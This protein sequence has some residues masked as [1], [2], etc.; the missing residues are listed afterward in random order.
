MSERKALLPP[1]VGGSSLLTVFAVLC[2][3]VFTVLAL[4]TVQANRRLGDLS[5]NAVTNYYAADCRAEAVLARL[6]AGDVPEGV[7]READ[8]T[9]SYACPV[10]NSQTLA[11]RVAVDGAEYRILRWQVI[12]IADWQADDRFPVWNG[13]NEQGGTA[14]G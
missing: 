3:T 11:V 6:R 2:L 12:S 10:S 14:D 4:S 8:G 9:Y 5:A 7:R 13:E 1:P